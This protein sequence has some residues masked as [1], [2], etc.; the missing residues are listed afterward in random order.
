MQKVFVANWKMHKTIEES[1]QFIVEFIPLVK[2]IDA[3]VLLAVPFTALSHAAKQV[4]G[5]NITV[6]AQNIDFHSKG[7]YTG[8]ISA[9]MVK[10]AGAQFVIVG[11]SER[12]HLFHETSEIVNLK[13]KAALA[14]GLTPLVCI[15]ETLEQRQASKVDG[16]LKEQ[17]L[18]SLA[19]IDADQ[20]GSMMLAYEPVW[21]I[22]TNLAATP[23]DVFSAHELCR[24]LVAKLWGAPS[25][26]ELP[27]LYGGSVRA[28]NAREL[29]ETPEVDGVLVGGASLSVESFSKIV[30]SQQALKY[31]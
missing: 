17:L 29:L 27:I 7:A 9:E 20:I 12:R 8:E 6:G 23:K 4:K 22:G 10:D 1:L 15:G 30:L 21:A 16:F 19:G 25:A 31:S 26:E 5:T 28:D 3:K 14:G 11:H 18:T 24:N 13:V 2:N